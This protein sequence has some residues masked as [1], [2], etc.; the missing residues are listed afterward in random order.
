MDLPIV[1]AV[2]MAGED[3]LTVNVQ[4]PAGTTSTSKLP[5]LFWIYGGGFGKSILQ[6]QTLR[7]QL[8]TSVE[9]GSTQMYDGSELISK[10]VAL[11]QPVLFV[12]VNHR[13]G[14]F[15]FLAGK[16]L[17]ADGSTNLGLRDQRKGLEWVAENVAAFGGDPSKVTIWGS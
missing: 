9:T 7:T 14:G 6:F 12:S 11:G 1:Q 16:E 17:Q 15:G 8:M 10:S 3:C 2:T 4:R 5:V 13:V